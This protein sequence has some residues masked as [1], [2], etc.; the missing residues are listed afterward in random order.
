M[1][2]M[3][4][5]PYSRKRWMSANGIKYIEL[6]VAYDGLAVMVNPKNTWVKSL[7]VAVLKKIWEPAAQGKIMKWNDIRAEWPNASLKLFGPGVDSGTFD[8]FTEAIVGKTKASRGDYT[9]SEDDNVLVMGIA[10]EKNSLGYFGLAYYEENR[11]KLKLIPIVN[12]KTREE[13]LPSEKTVMDG[14][15]QP[16]SRPIF[17][18]VNKSSLNKSEVKEFVEFYLKNAPQLVKEV[19]Y[20]PLPGKAYKLAQERF[21][22][23]KTGSMFGGEPEVGVKIEDLLA[24]EEKK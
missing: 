10:G 2:L 3:H 4:Q 5:G 6:P 1:Y 8:Y 17:I 19:K 18:Y 7:T 15:Y 13:V 24:R 12:P 14:T 23:V 9:S 11:D 16:L 22:K 20:I 21:S